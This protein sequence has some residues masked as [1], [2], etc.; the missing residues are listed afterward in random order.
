MAC[1]H[2]NAQQ[3]TVSWCWEMEEIDCCDDDI[4]TVLICP[5][6]GYI[7]A[8]EYQ[9]CADCCQ[10]NEG[11]ESFWQ[12]ASTNWIIPETFMQN[13]TKYT[14]IATNGVIKQP[15]IKIKYNNQ[16]NNALELVYPVGSISYNPNIAAL[17]GGTW[18]LEENW[19]YWIMGQAVAQQ[20]VPP[21]TSANAPAIMNLTI[22]NNDTDNTYF[23][24][25]TNLW[26]INYLSCNYLIHG[27]IFVNS[28][29]G[30]RSHAHFFIRN[31]DGGN[32]RNWD[33]TTCLAGVDSSVGNIGSNWR[34]VTLNGILPPPSNSINEYRLAIQSTNTSDQPKITISSGSRII[35][36]PIIPSFYYKRIA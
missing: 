24:S 14:A 32:W 15:T 23:S 12:N 4:Q 1:T 19:K 36:R 18:T 16:W 25:G 21:R 26:K 35:C 9:L 28:V 20:Y 2:S 33:D 7:K 11:A 5:D 29:S 10:G 8:T 31:Y 34:T 30:N 22:T 13:D 3:Q 6:C 17:V 27:T